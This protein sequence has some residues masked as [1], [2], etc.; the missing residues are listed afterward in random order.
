MAV[1][2]RRR[3][4]MPIRFLCLV[5]SLSFLPLAFGGEQDALAI[6]A[7]IQSRHMPYG[8]IMDPILSLPDLTQ[9]VDYT[10]CGD[11]AIWTGHY[12]AAEAFRYGVTS[13]AD[14]L[15]NIN[16]AISAIDNL[17][18]V[19]GGNVLARCALP[20]DS[21]Y[22]D[23]ISSQEAANGIYN[24]DSFGAPWIWVGN[25][26]RDQYAGVFF[27]LLVT[28]DL[29]SDQIVRNWCSYLVTRLLQN[30]LD[31]RWN[32]VMPDG[33]MS[34]TFLLRPDQQLAMLL[35]GR[36]VNGGAFKTAYS[37]E[38]NAISPTVTV[39]IGVDCVDQT[40]SYFK[41]NLD[42]L[43]FYTLK[44]L[45]SGYSSFW[46]GL[47]YDEL[48]TTTASHRNAHFNMI[49]RAIN[50]PNANRDSQTRALLDAWLLRPRTDAYRD[51][52]GQFT[53]CSGNEACQPLPVEDRVTTDFLWQ[54]DPFRL[55]GGA[56]G[57]IET[58]G[59]D[60]ILPY[61]MGRYYGVITE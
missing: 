14:A 3:L 32:V 8:G 39:P 57:D 54:R 28:Y 24:G 49:D 7:N 53:A 4:S 38:S 44:R 56:G 41:F 20:E 11:S 35:I 43:T 59:I 36:H 37:L 1:R 30:L 40:G 10:R 9:V 34:T 52:S 21:P 6:D 51:F 58:A 60:Y 31:N 25:T 47:A 50:G 48:R 33:R 15:A 26:S 23:S 17:I 2:I 16:S 13:A 55:S 29:V 22:A 18:N 61:W 27:G 12:L 19:T 45:G 5:A 46:Y 42:Y